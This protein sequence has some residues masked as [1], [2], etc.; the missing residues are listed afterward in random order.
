MLYIDSNVLIGAVEADLNKSDLIAF[1]LSPEARTHPLHTSE[2]TL[3]EVLVGPLRQS[4]HDLIHWYRR[5]FERADLL[6]LWP[7]TRAILETAAELRAA[8]AMR[9]PDAIHVATA[10]AA[11]CGTILSRDKRLFLTA[12]LRQIDPFAK[13]VDQWMGDIR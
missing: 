13:A 3:S 4:D 1:L 6:R 2:I 7:V 5:L 8:S 12:G 9:L 11:G 10:I